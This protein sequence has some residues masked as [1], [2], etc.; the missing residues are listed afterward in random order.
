[1]TGTLGAMDHETVH[2][3]LRHVAEELDDRPI[4]VAERG[5]RELLGKLDTLQSELE[6]LQRGLEATAGRLSARPDGPGR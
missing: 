4:A 6:R 5:A 2:A 3:R 1:M